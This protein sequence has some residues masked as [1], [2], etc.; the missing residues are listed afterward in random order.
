MKALEHIEKIREYCD[1]LERHL[2]NVKDSW[3]I[4]QD[5]CKD[6]PFIYDDYLFHSISDMISKHDLSKISKEEFI[7]YV[8]KF[9]PVK[10]RTG[11]QSDNF[12]KAW[13][14]HK[15]N[16]PHHWENWAN[17]EFYNPYEWQCH[18]VCMIVDWMAMGMEFGDTA[19]EYYE[20]QGSKIKLP[21][22]GV[23]LA[24]Q[25]FDRLTKEGA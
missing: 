13:K 6:L 23:T 2:K 12:P 3:I 15:E 21:E 14:H 5:K 4:L 17:R 8:E 10:Q 9:K 1:Y 11:A 22:S 18:C 7:P 19:Q 20:S 25:I 16:N 24:Y